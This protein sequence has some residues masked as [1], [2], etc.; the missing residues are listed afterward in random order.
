[1]PGPYESAPA[2]RKSSGEDREVLN[3]QNELGSVGKARSSGGMN[4]SRFVK[5]GMT[6]LA[7]DGRE[8]GTVDRVEG[9]RIWLEGDANGDGRQEFVPFALVD[10]V[11]DARVV[12]SGGWGN[13]Q[14]GMSS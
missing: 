8:I 2:P 11:D 6:V 14:F 3:N 7:S 4:A 13:A 10:G 5:A 12:L 9:D 1:M